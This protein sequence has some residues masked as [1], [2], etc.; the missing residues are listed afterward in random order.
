MPLAMR[1]VGTRRTGALHLELNDATHVF[2]V[3]EASTPTMKSH[4][5]IFFAEVPLPDPTI[6]IP[7]TSS[8]LRAFKLLALRALSVANVHSDRVILFVCR[9]G[10]NRSR[11]L[12]WAVAHALGIEPD[13]PPPAD[14]EMA[15]L[16][17]MVFTH[18]YETLLQWP[19]PRPRQMK[20]GRA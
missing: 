15:R 7:W 5:N 6:R 12:L 11:A 3:V 4:S 10:K 18:E 19:P 1:T 2:S 17:R 13:C 16:A 9:A 14:P 8:E 20:R